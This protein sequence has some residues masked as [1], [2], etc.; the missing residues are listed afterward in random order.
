MRKLNK[1]L[2][3]ED[4]RDIQIIAQLALT[5]I[6]HYQLHMC[7]D[8][9]QALEA[10]SDFQPDLVMLDVMMPNMDGPT[11]FSEMKK[12]DEMKDI[13]VLFITAGVQPKE[14]E[15]LKAMGALDII[16]KPFDPVTLG[17]NIENIWNQHINPDN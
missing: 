1:I 10:I 2:Y 12:R 17:Q 16:S 3:A 6:S 11:T 4:Q 8:G 14:I 13:P 7:N 9:E 15:Q 5:S